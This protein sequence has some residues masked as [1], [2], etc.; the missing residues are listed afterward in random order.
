MLFQAPALDD[1]E[2]EV[3][4]RIEELRRILGHA[5]SATPRRWYGLLRR[6]TFARAV[7]GSNSIEGYHVTVDDAIAAAEGEEPLEAR[8]EAWEAVKGYQ[9]AMTYVLQLATDLHFAYS[10]DLLRSL[11]FMMTQH[12]LKRNPGRWRPGPIFVRDDERGEVVYEGPD[13]ERVPGLMSELVDF[14]NDTSDEMPATVKAAMGHLNL[15]M[16]HPFSDGNGRMA[17]CLQTL[18]LARTGVLAPP[19]SSIEEYLGRNTLAYYEVLARVG[20]GRWNPERSCRPW[21][22]FC[23]TAHYRQART[24]VLRTRELEKL[25][26]ALEGEVLRRGLPERTLLALADAASG[27]RVRNATYRP[28][29]DISDHLASRDLKLLV[30]QGFLLAKGERRGRHYVASEDLLKIRAQVQESRQVEDPFEEAAPG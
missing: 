6:V 12:D 8:S 1:K 5:F 14:L 3:L 9:T 26:N 21:I 19:F 10:T 2:K 28:V 23:L 16:I 17:R 22:R 4:D 7:R 27:L 29:A 13:A 30:E 18:V 25:W 24:L 11:H 15:V 20:A